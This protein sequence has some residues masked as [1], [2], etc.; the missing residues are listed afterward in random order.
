[1]GFN[2]VKVDLNEVYRKLFDVD[3]G[4]KIEVSHNDITIMELDDIK[5]LKQDAYPL[6]HK[7][8]Y[9]AHIDLFIFKIECGKN[10]SQ[11]ISY[12]YKQV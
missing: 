6:L 5:I 8:L 2:T 12:Q 7:T 11:K 4:K 3:F 10:I 1:M 9:Q